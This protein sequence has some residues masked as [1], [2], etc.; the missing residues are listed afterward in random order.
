MYCMR[1]YLLYWI[2]FAS[3]HRSGVT[4]NMTIEEFYNRKEAIVSLKAAKPAKGIELAL[5]SVLRWTQHALFD[6]VDHFIKFVFTFES[7]AS[8]QEGTILDT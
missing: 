3:G 2:H 6:H 5:N 4:A 7:A 8:F 1:D